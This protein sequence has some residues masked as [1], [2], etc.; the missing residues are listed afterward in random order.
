MR[1]G[2]ELLATGAD[3]LR[4]RRGRGGGHRPVAVGDRRLLPARS[5]SA[6]DRPLHAERSV[7]RV[8][9]R[10]LRRLGGGQHRLAQCLP[11]HR[12]RRYPCCAALDLAGPR[13]RARRH[14]Q[15]ADGRRSAALSAEP[16]DVRAPPVAAHGDGRQR[17]C[18]LRQLWH[19]QL[20]PGLPDAYAGHAARCDGDLVRARRGHHLRD[21]HPRRRL[22]G[23]PRREAIAARLWIDS[24]AGHRRPDT[25]LRRGAP[26]R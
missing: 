16:C 6:G 13:T 9:R 14:G 22:A 25:Q 20:D 21:R 23:Q 26:R 17:P 24:R 19:A 7:R 12:R 15:A 5:P 8:R 10:R 4:R 3:A 1:D 11:G 18:R 2:V